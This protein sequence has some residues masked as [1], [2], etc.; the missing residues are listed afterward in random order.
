MFEGLRVG[1]RLGESVGLGVF[2]ADGSGVSLGIDVR[3]CVADAGIGEG[4]IVGTTPAALALSGDTDV[5]EGGTGVD[6]AGI[7]V[8]VGA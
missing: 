8:S 6:E 2:V 3:V 1:V 5:L 7:G 4:V